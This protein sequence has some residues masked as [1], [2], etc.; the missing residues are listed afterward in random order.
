MSLFFVTFIAL[1]LISTVQAASN[2]DGDGGKGMSITILAP[3]AAGLAE[4]QSH[5]PALIQGE[6]IS[7]FSAYSAIDV[8]DWQRREAI[9]VHILKSPSYSDSV[10][11]QTAREL[12]NL[13]PTTHFMD[14]KIMKTPTG[15]NLQMSII[16]NSD[17]MTTASYS[18]NFTFW[19][20]NNLTGIRRASLDL[21]P[22]MGVTLTE[23]A[24]QELAGAT[25]ANY[26]T[27]QTALAQGI[28]AQ[29]RGTEVAALSYYFQAAAFDPSLRE[30]VNRSSILNAN[31]TSGSMGDNIRNDIQWR[32]DWIERLEETERFFDS[33]NKMESMP[34]TLFYSS[35]IQRGKIDYENE[36]VNMSIGTY[37][38]GSGVWTL[39]IEQA[40]QAVYNGLR[41]TGRAGEWGLANWPQQ[42]VTNL[43]PFAKRSKTFFVVFEL[44]NNQDKVIG[45]QT[46]QA[47]GSWELNREGRPVI[48]ISA[49]DRKNLT[50]QNVSANDITDDIT[51]RVASVNGRD[52]EAA[53]IDGILQIR[54]IGRDE[55][56][57]NDRLIFSKGEIQGFTQGNVKITKLVVPNTIWGDPVVSIRSGAFNNTGLT[58]VTFPDG[59][60]TVIPEW[61]LN[62]VRQKIER[63]WLPPRTEDIA[64]AVT[65]KFYINRDGSAA[66]ITISKSSGNST[67]DNSAIRAVIRSSPFGK[68]PL[69]FSKDSLDINITLRPTNRPTDG[70]EQLHELFAPASP[71]RPASINRNTTVK[72]V[73]PANTRVVSRSHVFTD[74]RDGKK[75]R[76]VEIGDKTWM[77]ENLNFKTGDSWCYNDDVNNCR[78]TGRL[79]DW[80]TAI[81]AC[82]AGWRLPN[83]NDWNNLAEVAGGNSVAGKKLKSQTGWSAG[84]KGSDDFGFSALSSGSRRPGKVGRYQNILYNGTWWSATVDDNNNVWRYSVSFSADNLHEGVNNKNY[85]FSVRCIQE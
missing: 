34:Y 6:F 8:L 54:A 52:A 83:R 84:G 31:I 43:K 22:K 18:G 44:V 81:K 73:A 51:I 27:A 79:Y 4:N 23:K 36:T 16:R 69:C 48:D 85:G 80:N 78:K 65:V 11:T 25:Q 57:M 56:V 62:N 82:P 19:E 38:Y 7:N 20:L 15:Y 61:Y 32:K 77:A 24:K 37:L 49:L 75:Y 10:Q 66:V 3:Q 40:V 33:F 58:S 46:L 72:S 42:G 50:F 13:I 21:L 60:A 12:G 47:G 68:L 70:L 76:T 59:V 30:A 55:I 63:N 2:W 35:G 26:V 28:T 39:S 71:S 5:L 45:R 74:R 1:G 29:R 67:L 17:K 9:Y 53:A 14:G 41:A 64:L